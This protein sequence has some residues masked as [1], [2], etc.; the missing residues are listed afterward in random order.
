MIINRHTS[1]RLK[2][3]VIMNIQVAYLKIIKNKE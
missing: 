1:S 3:I 2:K